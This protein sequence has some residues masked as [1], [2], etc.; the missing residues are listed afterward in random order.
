MYAYA[1]RAHSAITLTGDIAAA[2]QAARDARAILTGAQID[3]AALERWLGTHDGGQ[4][5]D[6]F[7]REI[8]GDLDEAVEA[9]ETARSGK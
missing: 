3:V 5:I 7:V 2:H 1:D 8:R 6:E 4:T 9:L